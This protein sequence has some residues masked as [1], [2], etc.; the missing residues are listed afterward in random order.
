MEAA[1]RAFVGVCPERPCARHT[2]GHLQVEGRRQGVAAPAHRAA[3]GQ[4]GVGRP[5]DGRAPE[6]PQAGGPLEPVGEGLGA[7]GERRQAVHVIGPDVEEGGVVDDAL[8]LAH[9][10]VFGRPPLVL[11]RLAPQVDLGRIGRKTHAWT[12]LERVLVTGLAPPGHRRN[13]SLGR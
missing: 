11:D 2:V 7:V 4:D 6:G 3:L 10:S 5:G 13:S 1:G 9:Q 12:V 8:H